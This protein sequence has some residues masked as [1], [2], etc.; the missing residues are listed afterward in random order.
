METTDSEKSDTPKLGY[1]RAVWR[2][3]SDGTYNNKPLSESYFRDYYREKL[4]HKVEC[5][6]CKREVCMQQMKRH[7]N[8]AKFLNFQNKNL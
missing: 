4:S 8:T 6:F 2:Y 5:K 3:R 7:Q 1:G